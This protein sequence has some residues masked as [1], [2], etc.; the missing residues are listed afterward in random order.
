MA[1]YVWQSNSCTANDTCR[2]GRSTR[3]HPKVRQ[4]LGGD[5][6]DVT[7]FFAL[8]PRGDG[9]LDRET[10]GQTLA[11]VPF[12]LGMV[13]EEFLPPSR[14]KNPYPRAPLKAADQFVYW[15]SWCCC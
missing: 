14:A 13:H 2:S 9:E 3:T 12:D 6:P 7:G 5:D 8:A 11:L 10:L 1:E 15:F 4:L